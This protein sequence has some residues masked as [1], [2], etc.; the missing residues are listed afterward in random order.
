VSLETTFTPELAPPCSSPNRDLSVHPESHRRCNVVQRDYFALLGR[1]AY[2]GNCGRLD[3]FW[4]TAFKRCPY[5][6]TSATP[7]TPPESWSMFSGT[8][9]CLKSRKLI[10]G[11]N[12][13]RTADFPLGIDAASSQTFLSGALPGWPTQMPAP[14]TSPMHSS[15]ASQ[16]RRCTETRNVCEPRQREPCPCPPSSPRAPSSS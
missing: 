2:R 1:Y 4:L 7:P 5:K 12:T 15:K 16:L 8:G 10:I 11:W 14:S 3:K 9:S 6:S 13:P